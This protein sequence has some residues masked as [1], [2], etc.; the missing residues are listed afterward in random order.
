MKIIHVNTYR[1]NGGAGRACQRLDAALTGRGADSEVWINFSFSAAGANRAFSGSGIKKGLAAAGILFERLVVKLF[2][3]PVP[4]PFSFPVWGTDISR[5]P[6]FLE[7]D[8]IHLH[9]INHSFLRPRDI[10]RLAALNKPIVWTFHDSNAF[11]GGCHVRYTCTHFEQHCGNCPVLRSSGPGD[12]SSRIWKAKAEAYGRFPFSIVAPSGWMKQ[13]IGRSALLGNKTVHQVPNTLDTG[14]FRPM[15]R[16]AARSALG[17]PVDKFIILSGFMPSRND[18]HKGT[19]YLLEALQVLADGNEPEPA[20]VLLL[21]FG[22]R[23]AKHVPVFPVEARFLGTVSDDEKLAQCYAAAD[24]FVTPS[25]EDNL[26]N[27]V[28]ESLSCGTPVVAFTTGGIPDMVQHLENGYLAPYRSAVGLAEG[29]QWV[30]RHPEP[31]RL[32]EAARQTVM[33]RFSEAV[34]ADRHLALY[35]QLLEM[36]EG[37]FPRLS[38][39]TIVYN[40]VQDIGATL[41]SVT[42]QTWSNLE[43]IVVDGG[44][45]DGTLDVISRYR[46]AIASF[47]SEPDRGIYDAMNK[48]LERATG[49]YVIFMNSGDEFYSP[50]TVA[51]VFRSAPD[52]DIYYGE[53][54]M[55]D[56]QRH[57]LGRRRHQVPAQLSKRSFRFG[58]SVSHQAIYIRRSLAPAYQLRYRLS[59]DIDWILRALDKAD[60]IV[61]VNRYVARY[62]VGGMSKKHHLESLRERF[63]IFSAHYGWLPNVIN[64]VVIAFRLV[65]Y[66]FLHRR[67]ND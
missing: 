63:H 46:Q 64:H 4:I 37:F 39:I 7:A 23:D 5:H 31:R 6:I 34:V 49:D 33:S 47:S 40:N 61:A 44:S 43:Y 29:L 19:P 25:L 38:V 55:I 8:I 3:K 27:T 2:K 1:G 9:W 66:Y 14:L 57:S 16:A 62:L 13:S 59:A 36:P 30:Y 56:A 21:V 48:G 41:E 50:E 42:R 67:T 22:N 65:G 17:L 45:T 20:H 15:E 32:A 18:L 51:Q 54:E 12:W 26:P 52:A 24:V 28:M 60:K 58:M 35:R 53:T 11:T 10:A